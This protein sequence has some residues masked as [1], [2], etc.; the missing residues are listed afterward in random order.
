ME[1]PHIPSSITDL[2]RIDQTKAT[3][4]DPRSAEG[5]ESND[6]AREEFNCVIQEFC[7]QATHGGEE[8]Q[9]E[10]AAIDMDRVVFE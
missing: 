2:E 7:K 5:N 3:C 6:Y 1:P 9:E 10:E 4:S 8:L